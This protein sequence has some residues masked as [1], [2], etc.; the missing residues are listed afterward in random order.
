ML[1]RPGWIAFTSCAMLVL[2]AAAAGCRGIASGPSTAAPVKSARLAPSAVPTGSGFVPSAA[3]PVMPG[4]NVPAIKVNTVGYPPEWRK[5]A[6]FN[7]RPDA[8]VVTDE[9]GK[10]AY[11]FKPADIVDKGKDAASQDVVWQVDFTELKTPG[12]Y[13]ISGAGMKSD[14][15]SIGAG[16]YR[17]AL[18][19]ALKH[20][21][22]QRCRTKL[23]APFATW[24]GDEFTRSAPCHVHEDVAWDYTDYPQKKRKWPVVAGWHD[25][26]NYSQYVASAAPTAQALLSAFERHPELFKDGDGNVPESGNK[27]PDILDEA[28]WGLLWVLSM[29]DPASGALRARESVYDWDEGKPQLDKKPH[30]VAGVGTAST[31]KAASVLAVAARVYKRWDAVFAARCE[32]AS[33]AAWAFLEQHPERIL[34][35]GKGS[36]QSLWDDSTE[37]QEG[38]AR[39]IAAV[40]LWR[41]FRLPAA[42]ESAKKLL[43]DPETQPQKFFDGAWA[44]LSRWGLIEL[45]FDTKTPEAL[46]SDAKQRLLAAVEQARS[47]IETKDGYRCASKPGDYYWGH[48]SNLLEKAHQLALALALDPS[49]TWLREALR[50]QWHWILGRNPIGYSMVT[51]IGKGPERLYHTEWS[52]VKGPV[53]GYLL[54]GPNA[55]EMGFLAPG[56]PAKTIVWD[57]DKP[58]R[59]GLPAHSL[60]HAAQSDLWDGGFVAEGV[61]SPGWWAVTEPDIYYNGNLVLVAAELQD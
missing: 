22:L 49:R 28:R 3:T 53:P 36:G 14:T 60:W 33:R 57:N 38:G 9:S 1:L 56:A 16:L 23:E 61:T 6:I 35:D 51:R 18:R 50:D 7:V 47:Q 59:S 15:F 8:A 45:A 25:A 26:G 55:S 10:L 29:Q 31:A 34:V 54:G 48:N 24:K 43:A 52:D 11:T 37:Y 12:R 30:W 44:D 27:V 13:F 41:S 32:K 5:I 4:K 20:F 42:L 46:R 58:L 39:F 40:E 21:Y 19:A 17:E 2:G